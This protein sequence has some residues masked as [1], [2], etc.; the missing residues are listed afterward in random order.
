MTDPDLSSGLRR[1]GEAAVGSGLITRLPAF[2]QAPTDE[3]LDLRKDLRDPLRRYRASTI[4]FSKELQPAIGPELEDQVDDLWRSKV[5]PALLELKEQIADHALVAELARHACQDPRGFLA[6]GAGVYMGLTAA[7]SLGSA[8]DVLI[9]AAGGIATEV[10]R[11][12]WERHK[13]NLAVR[14]HDLFFL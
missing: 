13:A 14:R 3:L 5:D 9:S 8:A 11:S 12:A 6:G 2:P 10:G 1:A 4:A 7:T